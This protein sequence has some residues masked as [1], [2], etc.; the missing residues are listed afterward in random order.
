M[1]SDRTTRFRAQPSFPY[2]L[3]S[4]DTHVGAVCSMYLKAFISLALNSFAFTPGANDEP[5]RTDC[6]APQE[7]KRKKRSKFHAAYCPQTMLRLQESYLYAL[8]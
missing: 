7:Q 8:R 1:A 2:L 3:G 6:N 4:I 5:N